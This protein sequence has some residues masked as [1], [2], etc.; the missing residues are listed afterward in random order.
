MEDRQSSLR[1]LASATEFQSLDEGLTGGRW[2]APHFKRQRNKNLQRPGQYPGAE[3]SGTTQQHRETFFA[4]HE[5]RKTLDAASESRQSFPTR[6]QEPPWYALNRKTAHHNKVFRPRAGDQCTHKR[7]QQHRSEIDG[8]LP[9]LQE[10]APF[11]SRHATLAFAERR[12]QRKPMA[13]STIITTW[14]RMVSRVGYRP[15]SSL[16]GKPGQ[17]V[18][19]R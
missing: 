10:V 11:V 7:A 1:K 17:G 16:R 6:E 14:A 3:L 19:G 12:F 4:R 15:R 13:S 18:I 8:D 5:A 2:T 9:R